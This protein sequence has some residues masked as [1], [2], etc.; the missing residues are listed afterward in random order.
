MAIFPLQIVH[1]FFFKINR[2]EAID[3]MDK[4]CMFH[5]NP[6]KNVDYLVNK[7][8]ILT[9]GQTDG[10]MTKATHDISSAGFEPVEL[11]IMGKSGSQIVIFR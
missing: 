11:K 3:E 5:E 6:T 8:K 2:V 7:K 4:L 1:F 10:W 9:D